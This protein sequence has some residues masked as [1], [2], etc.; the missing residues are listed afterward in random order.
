MARRMESPDLSLDLTLP[1]KLDPTLDTTR[2]TLQVFVT[3]SSPE[4]AFYA[5][6]RLF[7]DKG[8]T[9]GGPADISIQRRGVLPGATGET[10]GVVLHRLWAVPDS[11]PL[12]ESERL[13]V[14]SCELIRNG[15]GNYT[16][17]WEIRS[18]KMPMK[19][20]SATLHWGSTI[21]DITPET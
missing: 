7:V 3:N 15:S 2:V 4:P 6:I 19:N 12:L 11:K 8:L 14:G 9:V 1:T 21:L 13:R 20:G 18:P 5:T 16:L 17:R 10:A